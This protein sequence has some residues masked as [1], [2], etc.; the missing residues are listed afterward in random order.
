[1]GSGRENFPSKQLVEV[2]PSV[3][4]I[5]GGE[6]PSEDVPGSVKPDGPYWKRGTTERSV[7]TPPGHL[8]QAWHPGSP[9]FQG[10]LPCRKKSL[11]TVDAAVFSYAR[12]L[13]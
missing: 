9:C 13:V 12:K 6:G 10:L 8:S 4:L 5:G 11:Q 2:S 1:M 7:G 3:S